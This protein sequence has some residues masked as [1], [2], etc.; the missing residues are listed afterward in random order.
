MKFK[1]CLV[2]VTRVDLFNKKKMYR[3]LYK[4]TSTQYFRVM[5]NKHTGIFYVHFFH[6]NKKENT[7][8]NVFYL[9]ISTVFTISLISKYYLRRR[10]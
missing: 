7:Q 4:Y 10:S 3:K 6:S 8:S 5:P 2:R 1:P 9:Q